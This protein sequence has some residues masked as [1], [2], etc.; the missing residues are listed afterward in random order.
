VTLA[1][2]C[3]RARAVRAARGAATAEPAAEF[4][5]GVVLAFGL[6]LERESARH[7]DDIRGIEADLAELR[8]TH[9]WLGPALGGADA[10]EHVDVR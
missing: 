10:L 8:E 4:D 2:L 7:A 3:A 6:F 9:S 1:D 5:A